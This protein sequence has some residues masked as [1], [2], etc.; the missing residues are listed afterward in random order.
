M[1]SHLSIALFD[2]Q[3]SWLYLKLTS[4]LHIIKHPF[5][6]VFVMDSLCKNQLEAVVIEFFHCYNILYF[7]IRE[8]NS[9]PV[10]Q[11]II[12]ILKHT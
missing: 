3:G 8:K 6:R 9:T 7:L 11:G 5:D 12:C 2:W 1:M 4:Y 10:F